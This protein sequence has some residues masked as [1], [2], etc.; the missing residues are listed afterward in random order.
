[1]PPRFVNLNNDFHKLR[2][3]LGLTQQQLADELGISRTT[4]SL[5]EQDK[6]SPSN[7]LRI[8][9][10]LIKRGAYKIPD[11]KM[12]KALTRSLLVQVN[13]RRKMDGENDY[14]LATLVFIKLTPLGTEKLKSLHT[15]EVIFDLPRLPDLDISG[16][17][18]PH[19]KPVHDAYGKGVFSDTWEGILMPNGP[20]T[21]DM[22]EQEWDN[23]K[24]TVEEALIK[25]VEKFLNMREDKP[26]ARVGG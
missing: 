13:M 16:R 5:L 17:R 4:L 14:R 24:A 9:M 6:Y 11:T 12:Q 23:V 10:E 20:N 15:D 18:Y 2:M 26:V 25:N 21:A 8:L 7:T 3:G 1:M 19:P 22:T